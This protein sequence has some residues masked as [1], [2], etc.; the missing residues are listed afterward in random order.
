MSN[1]E[2]LSSCSAKNFLSCL[3]IEKTNC[4]WGLLITFL[5]IAKARSSLYLFPQEAQ[6][7]EL[8]DKPILTKLLQLGH[9]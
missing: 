3:A 6:N 2:S 8:Q 1:R 4:L 5:D 9:S 7:L